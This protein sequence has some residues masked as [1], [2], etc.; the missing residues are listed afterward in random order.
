MGVVERFDNIL[1]G[2]SSLMTDMLGIIVF[3]KL[4]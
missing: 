3:G 1:F 4:R 2:I